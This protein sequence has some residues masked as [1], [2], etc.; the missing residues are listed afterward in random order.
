MQSFFEVNNLGAAI[1]G[2]INPSTESI[3][4][5]RRRKAIPEKSF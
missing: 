5:T 4:P 1:H 3:F 2:N